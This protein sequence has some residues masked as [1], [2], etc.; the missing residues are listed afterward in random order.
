MIAMLGDSLRLPIPDHRQDSLREGDDMR[1]VTWWASL[2]ALAAVAG[3]AVAA[4][5]PQV[6]ADGVL[7]AVAFD[8]VPSGS[9]VALRLMD[10]SDDNLSLLGI[11]EKE[12]RSRGYSVDANAPLVLDIETS[13]EIGAWS[14]GDRR[15]MF[16]LQARSGSDGTDDASL[17][18]NAFDSRTGGVFN[19]G[20]DN[21]TAIV[22]PSSYR[23]DVNIEDSRNGKRLWQGWAVANAR[24]TSGRDLLRAMVPVIVGAV[25]RT[26]K[27][28]S[29]AVPGP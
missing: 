16:E 18:L 14:T 29:F 24:T 6:R 11:F 2:L 10:N 19:E 13:D 5:T 20:N 15:T 1:T 4:E 28:A 17:R 3:A 22:T 12:L 7:N 21:R 8:A 25:G 26:E 27:Q 9:T 23:I